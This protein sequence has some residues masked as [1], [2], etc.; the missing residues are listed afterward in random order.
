[1]LYI[2]SFPNDTSEQK[3]YRFQ[4]DMAYTLLFDG[5]FREYG[6][7]LSENDLKISEKGKPF[8]EKFP[9]IHFSVSHTKGFAACFISEQECG[10]DCEFLRKYNPKVARRVFSKDEQDYADD[11]SEMFTE[12]W[13]MKESYGKALGVGLAYNASGVS[14]VQDGNIIKHYGEY[15]FYTEYKDEYII[16][17]CVRSKEHFPGIMYV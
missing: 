4:H 15:S 13:T 8:F 6:L 16:T 7:K 2:T 17:S 3:K 14:F 5:V 1:M 10:V 11:S 12:I 9:H